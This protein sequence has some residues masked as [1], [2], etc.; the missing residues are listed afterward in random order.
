M[1]HTAISL[2]TET[3]TGSMK[4]EKLPQ[5][6]KRIKQYV[7]CQQHMSQQMHNF[8]RIKISDW[9][10]RDTSRRAKFSTPSIC[11]VKY[12]QKKFKSIF[13]Y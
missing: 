11:T 10:T 4:A 6:F 5:N 12:E 1:Q 9:G 3:D 2:I 13:L 8:L 7:V